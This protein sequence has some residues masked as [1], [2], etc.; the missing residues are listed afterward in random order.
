MQGAVLYRSTTGN[1]GRYRDIQSIDMGE[2][3]AGSLSSFDPLLV[4]AHA[5]LIF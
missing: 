1:A 5:R 4:D 3:N 2:V